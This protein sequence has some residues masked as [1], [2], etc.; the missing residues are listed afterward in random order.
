MC[1]DF[2]SKY[3]DENKASQA[4]AQN[5]VSCAPVSSAK[6]TEVEEIDDIMDNSIAIIFEEQDDNCVGLYDSQTTSR[7][8]IVEN[9]FEK[10]RINLPTTTS[11]AISD[12]DTTYGSH[13]TQPSNISIPDQPSVKVKTYLLPLQNKLPPN[14]YN[15]VNRK[16]KSLFI[17]EEYLWEDTFKVNKIIDNA[18]CNLEFIVWLAKGGTYVTR[19]KKRKGTM[20][21]NG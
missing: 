5:K 4:S 15:K 12:D 8:K 2:C 3:N 11:P 14:D 18:K 1:A 7:E 20:S 10:I 17:K 19:C 6:E 9:L 16:S 21:Q 13:T